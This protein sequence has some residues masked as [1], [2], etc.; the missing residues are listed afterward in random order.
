MPLPTGNIMTNEQSQQNVSTRVQRAMAEL[1]AKGEAQRQ[2]K[3]EKE[4]Q[5]IIEAAGKSPF[6][7]FL[8]AFPLDFFCWGRKVVVPVCILLEIV[9]DGK[10]V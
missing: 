3:A 10:G 6:P 1:A 7:S 9:L 8:L 4:K 5:D 2:A